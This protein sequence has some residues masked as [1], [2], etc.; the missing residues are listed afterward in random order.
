MA[1]TSTSTNIRMEAANVTWGREEE[2]CITPATGLTGG[3][4]FKL[5]SQNE[6]FVFYTTVN[7]AGADP[8]VAGYTSVVVAVNTAYTVAEWITAFITAAEGAGT[9]DEFLAI[10]SSDGLSVKVTTLD[11]GAVL[12]TAADVDTGFTF[13][14]DV[15]GIGG[16]LGK[17][18]EGIE[19]AFEQSKFEVMANQTGESV[20]DEILMGLKCSLSMSLLEMTS[21][22]WQLI[23]GKG[24]GDV[25]TPSGGT[26][27]S[28]F[29]DGRMN[30]SAFSLGGKL[31]LHPVN[32]ASTDRSR[33]VVFHKCLPSPESVNF[34]GTD[35]QAMSV[36]FNAYVDESKDASI[37]IFA[38]GDWR[39]DL[40]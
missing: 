11:V 2:T 8:S 34:D 37:N 18:K 4:Y 25:H 26:I 13:S 14:V 5:S 30:T 15:T 38:F 17:T 29:G 33:D 3:E 7:A 24:Y 12:E 20:L 1:C 36:T 23:V 19:I 39:Q 35:T 32:L 22:N 21:A 6:K 16:D 10:A 28:G 40:R 9:N 31:I 27:L